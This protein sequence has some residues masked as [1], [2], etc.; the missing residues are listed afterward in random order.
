M[1]LI[2]IL[3]VLTVFL[4]F[5]DFYRKGVRQKEKLF[6]SR[7]ESDNHNVS[8]VY[9]EKSFDLKAEDNDLVY[10]SLKEGYILMYFE[11]ENNI[12]I[13]DLNN[14]FSKRSIRMVRG[15]YQKVIDRN[16]IFSVLA[17]NEQQLFESPLIGAEKKLIVV[18]NYKKIISLGYDIKECCEDMMDTIDIFNKCY[19]GIL[20]N[21][22]GIRLT[23]KDRQKYLSVIMS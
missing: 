21:E 2:I 22:N 12:T 3:V 17:D 13:K 18:M 11:A 20:L 5:I 16:V 10:E 8:L 9:K 23:K 19:N 1:F 4:V 6:L 15:V 14:F 7:I